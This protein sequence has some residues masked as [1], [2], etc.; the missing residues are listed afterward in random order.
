VH[1]LVPYLQAHIGVVLVHR[2]RAARLVIAGCNFVETEKSVVSEVYLLW[3]IRETVR[4]PFSLTN[5]IDAF[6]RRLVA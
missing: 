4:E 6:F 5:A 2:E 1:S 3:T